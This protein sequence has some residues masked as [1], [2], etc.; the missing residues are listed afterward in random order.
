M[1]F[2][3]F[4]WLFGSRDSPQPVTGDEFFDLL[5]DNY[6]REL[7]FESCVNLVGNIVSKCEIKTYSGGEEVKGPEYYLWNYAP[8]QNQNSTSFWHK[9]IYQ[10]YHN[11]E[12]LVI[13]ND[14]K[15]YVADSYNRKKYALYDDVFSQVAIDDFTF[16]Q[17]FMASNVLF[18]E[19]TNQDMKQ[20]VDGLYQ[21]YGKLIQYGMKGYQ[22]SRG[23]KGTL[24]LD[25]TASGDTQF[26]Q[27]YE[28]IKNKGFKTFAEAENAV[29]PLYKGM[30]YTPTSNKTYSSDTTR[31]IRAMIDDVTDFYARGFG[32]PA[33]LLNGSVQD[34]SSAT[35]QLLTFCADPLADNLA[36]EINR[37]RYGLSDF[38]KGNYLKIDT[39]CIKHVDLIESA[40]NIDK[41]MGSGVLCVNDIRVL[42]G[43]PI[44]PEKW[45][46]QHFITKNYSAIVDALTELSG[47]EK[48]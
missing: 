5:S 25:M 41:L 47:G 45:A 44:I 7:A 36:E 12:A 33:P 22:K 23:E 20:I 17:T 42:L 24:E 18:F 21:S 2:N 27:T 31:D 38:Q 28:D 29:L 1:A 35:D 19:L 46:Y 43:Q 34:V 4:K 37:K 10:L 30:K 11:R 15:L 39:S 26:L 40:A 16:N 13:E 32:I 3:F 48:E 14:G 6:I 8:N 9:L